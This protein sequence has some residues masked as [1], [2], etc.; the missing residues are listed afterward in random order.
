[1]GGSDDVIQNVLVVSL[2]QLRG[3]GDRGDAGGGAGGGGQRQIQED[4]VGLRL[5][6]LTAQYCTPLFKYITTQYSHSVGW[7]RVGSRR[8][9]PTLS[10]HFVDKLMCHKKVQLFHCPVSSSLL[11]QEYIKYIFGLHENKKYAGKFYKNTKLLNDGVVRRVPMCTAPF[12]LTSIMIIYKV[13]CN[14]VYGKQFL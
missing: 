8:R 5:P 4:G 2:L 14:R 6:R 12:F 11:S 1:M 7:H 3:S 13:I 10:M 9:L